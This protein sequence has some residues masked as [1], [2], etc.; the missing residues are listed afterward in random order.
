MAS[1]KFQA[2]ECCAL[3]ATPLG[4]VRLFSIHMD[5]MRLIWIG[6]DFDLLGI[7]SP[8]IPSIHMDWGRTEHSLNVHLMPIL[9]GY[10]IV[11]SA[12]QSSLFRT[13]WPFDVYPAP[14]LKF[15]YTLTHSVV[16]GSQSLRTSGALGTCS[17]ME[18]SHILPLPL[19]LFRSVLYFS[20]LLHAF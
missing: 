1:W 2:K 20:V 10:I 17:C 6:G 4:L 19:S 8:S 13:F 16:T 9:L 5:W 15:N 12:N 14:E 7:K 11:Q 18:I 3:K